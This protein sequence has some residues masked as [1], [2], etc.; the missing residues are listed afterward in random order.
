VFSLFN[1][2]LRKTR[3][4]PE[5]KKEGETEEP[6]EEAKNEDFAVK[7]DETEV[8]NQGENEINRD[9]TPWVKTREEHDN[10]ECGVE[11]IHSYGRNDG[12]DREDYPA[13]KVYAW[14]NKNEHYSPPK[15]M[16]TYREPEGLCLILRLVRRFRIF[17]LGKGMVLKFSKN[18]TIRELKVKLVFRN[19]YRKDL[20]L[21]FFVQLS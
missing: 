5:I 7:N 2:Y 11:K 4:E 12:K 17:T 20:S 18:G 19:F 14:K 10:N 15:L 9:N 16:V 6:K 1:L 21:L 8:I 3:M 13:K